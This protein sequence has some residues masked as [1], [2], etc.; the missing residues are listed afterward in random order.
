MKPDRVVI[1]IE[2][3]DERAAAMMQELYAPFTRTGAPIMVMDCAERRAVQVRG[4]RDARDAH[5]VH[6]R[7]RQ[8]LRAGRRRRRSGAQGDR[9]RSPHRHVVPVSGRRLRRQLLSEG[10]EGADASRRP[11][12]A[13]TSG[14]SRPSRT[15]TRAEGAAGREDGAA[16]RH[17]EG[18]DDRGLGPGVQAAHRRHAR[19]AGDSDHRAA[20]R[21][22]RDGAGLRSGGDRRS[23]AASSATA[24]ALC[25]KSYDALEGR[26]RA[27]DR[28]RVER[29]PRARLRAR[30]GSCSRR[31]S[32]STAATSTRPS[33]C[34]R[35]ASPTTPL[36]ADRRT[37]L[38]T[39]GAGY[40]GSHAAK[41]LQ[42]RR[43]SRRR[44]RQSRRP[45][46]REAVQ[47]RRAGRRRHHR[48]R[49]GPPRRCARTASPRSCTSPRCSTSASRCAIRRLL[50]QQRRRRARRCS[51]RWPRKAWR[52]S[53]FRRPARPT[54]SRSRR[55]SPKPIR[56]SRSTATARP[57]WRSSARCRISSAPTACTAVALRYF[58]AAGADPDGE[59][60]EDHAPEIH[61]IPRAIEAATGGRAAAGLR[62]RLSD[63]R[64]HLSARLHPRHRSGRRARPRRSKRSRETGASAAYNLGTGQPHSVREVIAAVE[65]VTGR[66]VPWTLGAAPARRSG[67][68][69]RRAAQGAGRAGLDA[70]RSPTRRDRAHAWHWHRSASA[71]LSRRPRAHRDTDS[72]HS[73]AGSSRYARPYRGR[74][75]WAR[76]RHGRLRRRLRRRSRIS[77]K[78]IFDNVLPNQQR[79]R[80]RSCVGDR[81][82]L[83]AEGHRLLRL[84]VPDGR[85][86][87]AGRDGPAQRAVRHIL[88]QSAGFFAQRT[89]GQL[90]SRINNDVGQV[91]QA[92]SETVGDLARESLA[93]VGF[94]GAAVLLR[95]AAGD[96]LPDRRAA[97]RLSAGA[98]R[99]ARA[100]HDAAQPGGAR[101]DLAPQRRSVH[102][103]SH[104]QGVR[105]RGARGGQVQ[106]APAIT[107]S[108]RT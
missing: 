85:R 53:S 99:P 56:S 40:I 32:S 88:G 75:V 100:P 24:I 5:L 38:V 83:S 61:L 7:D 18:Q 104:R 92:V 16:L 95:R 97:G 20:A 55:R 59:I 98:A 74:L 81:R 30:C 6:E 93:L 13:T 25:E 19:G 64:R 50:P 51:K 87:A 73:L 79:R 15:S 105:H 82:R 3:G 62:R 57:S 33:R 60:G 58:N 4:Q 12:R 14:F 54:A 106:R 94:A 49:R 63:A 43:L 28:H 1:G 2:T 39:G 76:A 47:V 77:I 108:A 71:R 102:R 8:R 31:R 107:C 68:A 42:R 90:L 26:R 66:P 35:S 48:R 17:A 46:H 27:G 101:A 103:P 70:A 36:A 69:V 9:L 52:T 23:R 45:G 37:V 80:V 96:R 86:R 21:D 72:A 78:P 11:T 44:L 84:V 89:T 29:V 41:A 67:G 10:R 91:Q 22:G 34:A 65:R